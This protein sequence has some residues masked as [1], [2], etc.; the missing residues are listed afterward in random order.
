MA[1]PSREILKGLLARDALSLF[2]VTRVLLENRIRGVLYLKNRG[3]IHLQGGRVV[4]AR[5]GDFIRNKALYRIWAMTRPTVFTVHQYAPVEDM[6]MKLGLA[7]LVYVQQQT[8][9]YF[10]LIRRIPPDA[11]VEP[12]TDHLEGEIGKRFLDLLSQPQ[13]VQFLLD[14]APDLPDHLVLRAMARFLA[15]GQLRLRRGEEV[16]P[17]TGYRFVNVAIL[18]PREEWL[19]RFYEDLGLAHFARTKGPRVQYAYLELEHARFHLYGIHYAPGMGLMHV[20]PFLEFAHVN[21]VI[22]NLPME[23]QQSGLLREQHLHLLL[24]TRDGWQ[25]PDRSRVDLPGWLRGILEEVG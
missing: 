5:H 8:D 9:E 4:G 20:R 11:T 16:L 12:T 25:L 10:A 21:I 7:D 19:E 22:G 2:D 23:L 18:S 1:A 6:G 17:Y 3:E 13:S 24:R 15:A 14:H